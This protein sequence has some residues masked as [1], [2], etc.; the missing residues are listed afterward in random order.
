MNVSDSQYV[1]VAE[2]GKSEC[3]L[4][5]SP[6]EQITC[7]IEVQNLPYAE[8]Q[9][10]SAW[11]STRKK[12]KRRILARNDIVMNAINVSINKPAC[13][14]RT[15]HW[16]TIDWARIHKYVRKLRQRIFRAEQQGMKRKVRKLQRLMVVSKANLL[17]SIKKVTQINKGKHTAGIDG[18]KAMTPHEK[19][20]LYDILRNNSVKHLKALPAKRIYIPKKRWQKTQAIGDT[21]NKRPNISEYN[22]KCIG[23][24]MGSTVRINII[25]ISSK[26]QHT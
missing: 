10:T 17:L 24:S 20:N 18:F 19:M 1:W 12:T 2:C 8:K 13:H 23:A 22:Q 3:R 11:S 9:Q 5:E 6:E 4:D 25:W 21:C 26:A 15:T 16:E 14:L 7:R